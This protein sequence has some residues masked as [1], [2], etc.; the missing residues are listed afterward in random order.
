MV[1]ARMIDALKP[2][3]ISD[4]V[5]QVADRPSLGR[6]GG[7]GKPGSAMLACMRVRSARS[8]GWR[9]GSSISPHG[10]DRWSTDPEALFGLEVAPEIGDDGRDPPA[11]LIAKQRIAGLA[12]HDHRSVDPV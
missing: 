9:G 10:R 1:A 7:D 4:P 2:C 3:F 11:V 5:R 6:S 12:A 8:I